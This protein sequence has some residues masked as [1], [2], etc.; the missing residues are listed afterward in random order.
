MRR[1]VFESPFIRTTHGYDNLVF[2]EKLE[3]LLIDDIAERK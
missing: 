1:T 2:L 3:I